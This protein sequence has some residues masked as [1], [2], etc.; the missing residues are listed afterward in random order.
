MTTLE[1]DTLIIKKIGTSLKWSSSLKQGDIVLLNSTNTAKLN[2]NKGGIKGILANTEYKV[3]TDLLTWQYGVHFEDQLAVG[4]ATASRDLTSITPGADAEFTTITTSADTVVTFVMTQTELII[5][6]DEKTTTLDITSLNGLN[7]RPWLSDISGGFSV[8][9][10]LIK[11][12]KIT[13]NDDCEA[14]FDTTSTDGSSIPVVFTTGSSSIATGNLSMTGNTL[15]STDTDGDISILPNGTGEVLL[16]TDPVSLLGAA[17]KQYVDSKKHPALE[18]ARIKT[19]TALSAYTQAGTGVGATLTADANGAL[20]IDS[21]LIVVADR[22]LV[23]TLGSTSDVHNGIYVATDIGSAGTPWILTRA[24]DADEAGDLTAGLFIF[25]EEGTV[26]ADSGW[27]I[28]TDNPFTIDTDPIVWIQFS[29][30]GTLTAAN[31]G[32]GDGKVFRDKTGSVLNFKSVDIG[33]TKL[34]IVNG[35]DDVTL[36]ID[37]SKII[38]TGAL[39]TGSIT[40]GFGNIDVGTSSITASSIS[41]TSVESTSYLQLA[42]LATAGIGSIPTTDGIILHN[43][44]NTKLNVYSGVWEEIAYVSD[45]NQLISRSLKHSAWASRSSSEVSGWVSTAWSPVLN[46][47]ATVAQ[48]GT[49]RAMSSADGITWTTRTIQ[50]NAWNRVI[51]CSVLNIFVAVGSGPTTRVATSTNGTSWTNRTIPEAIGL[52]DASWSPELGLIVAVSSSGTDRV[53]TSPDGITWTARTVPLFAW[54]TVAWSSSLSLFVS[55]TLGGTAQSMYSS[56]GI[57]WTSQAV[58]SRSYHEAI[59]CNDQNKFVAVHTTGVASSTDGINWTILGVGG[60]VWAGIS[61]SPEA[62]LFVII[63][64]TGTAVATS[65]NATTWTI[66]VAPEAAQ[67]TSIT[68]SPSLMRFVGV[69]R[70]GANQVMISN[71]STENKL[72]DAEGFYLNLESTSILTTDKKLT[73]DTND[74]DRTIDLGGDLTIAGDLTTAGAYALTLTQTATTAVTLPTTGTLIAETATES[75]ITKPLRLADGTVALPAY[76]LT[77]DIDTGFYKTADGALGFSS[78]GTLVSTLDSAGITVDGDIDMGTN[79]IIGAFG[80]ANSY[81]DFGGLQEVRLNCNATQILRATANGV[82]ITGVTTST[83]AIKSNSGFDRVN[84]GALAIGGAIATSVDISSAG[85][86][87]TI[88]GA[89]K[90]D[91]PVTFPSYT[92]AGVPSATPAGQQIF[93]SNMSGTPEM[94]FSNGTNWLRMSDLTVIS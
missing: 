72:Q 70:A 61:W 55:L 94:A 44:D 41:G 85:D 84:A 76:S 28:S 65:P 10:S 22:I 31:V 47:F 46:I 82:N 43:S 48:F 90:V 17:T 93:V 21:V 57:S 69:G 54:K 13:I 86:T 25:I 49:N 36:D 80:V 38:E 27:I 37:E 89:L 60:G 12:L 3:G 91:G 50:S 4:I 18:A 52:L 5:T 35:A 16:K 23:D 77:S 87:T 26:N 30:A 92:L 63:D 71:V 74:T 42:D 2:A 56:D 68:W 40:S 33:S 62:Q 32:T 81:I 45:V 88:K 53:I 34:T 11:Q 7:V 83:G 8:T 67:W 15:I 29:Q 51:W 73:F 59:W 20:T 6:Y 79:K 24:D 9:I 1:V 19:Q 39:N 14:I 75:T 78:N 58:T 66:E 64:L